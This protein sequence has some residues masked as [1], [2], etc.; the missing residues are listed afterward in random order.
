MPLLSLGVERFQLASPPILPESLPTTHILIASRTPKMVHGLWSFRRHPGCPKQRVRY[1]YH[2]VLHD[3]VFRREAKREQHYHDVHKALA[4][5]RWDM[6]V[7]GTYLS[8]T[9]RN[10]GRLHYLSGGSGGENPL[11]AHLQV[12]RLLS[13]LL[14]YEGLQVCTCRRTGRRGGWPS[15]A[16]REA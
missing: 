16:M 1:D 4:G 12:A 3:N 13:A 6:E 14:V 7:V 11:L 15:W 5:W 9:Q 2:C 8:R 10:L